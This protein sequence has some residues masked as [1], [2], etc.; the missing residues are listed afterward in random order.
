MEVQF[1]PPDGQLS[2]FWDFQTGATSTLSNPSNIFINPG[3]Y[4]VEYKN[5]QNGPVVGTITINVYP[6]PVLSVETDT[7][8]GCKPLSVV[9]NAV[10]DLAPEI[11]II[12]YEWV[13]G[14]GGVGNSVPEIGHIYN[15]TGVFSPSLGI[16]TNIESCNTTTIFEDLI[17]VS[18]VDNVNFVTSPFPAVSCEPPLEVSFFNFTTG[19]GYIYDWDFG[20]GN[21]F[22]GHMP[23]AEIYTELGNYEVSLTV[24]DTNQ[25]SGMLTRMVNIG[26][27][28]AEFSIPDT[29]CIRDSVVAINLSDPGLYHWESD[30]TVDYFYRT[31]VDQDV[32]IFNAPGFHDVTLTV[33]LPDSSCSSSVTKTVFVD[34]AIGAFSSDP[35]YSCEA[36]MTVDFTPESPDAIAWQ[37]T[38]PDGSISTEEFPS[39]TIEY[40]DEDPFSEYGRK[41][42]LTQLIVTNPSGCRDTITGVDTLYRPD[43]LFMPDVINGCAPL[44]VVFS[45]SSSSQEQ[46]INWHYTFGDGE[47]A[48]LGSVGDVP[49]TYEN[50]G[51]YE[52]QLAIENEAGCLDT[53]YVVTIE[54]GEPIDIDFEPDQAEI[55]P[56]DT[57]QFI[58]LFDSNEIDA[59]HFETDD[60][61]SFHC[62]G[63]SDLNWPFVT[64]TGSYD[65]TLTVEHNG[66]YSTLTKEDVV[67]VK[68]PIAKIDYQINCDDPYVVTFRDSSFDATSVFWEFG[69]DEGSNNSDIDHEYLTTG[70]Y[71]V[72]LTAFN[73]SSG[74]PPDRDT[75]LVCVR[76]LQASFTMNSDKICLGVAVQLDATSSV[77]VDAHCGHGYDWYFDNSSR[78]ITTDTFHLN[79]PTQVTGPENITLVT[80]DVNGCRDT[81]TQTI[82]IYQTVADYSF[83]DLI[84]CAN[85]NNPTSFT[86]L[87]VGDTTLVS[88]Q[89]TFGDGTTSNEQN[90]D[91]IF[92]YPLAPDTSYFVQLLVDDVL[93][94]E[95]VITYEI[96]WYEPTSEISTFPGTP[97]ICIGDEVEFTAADYTAQGSNLIY[98]WD[99]GNGQQSS[100]QT[101][102]VTYG[103]SGIFLVNLNYQEASSGCS[104]T[105]NSLVNVQSYPEA[106]FT[107]SVDGQGVICYP[108]NII[109]FDDSNSEHPLTFLWDFGNGQ[110][111]FGSTPAASFDKGTFSIQMIASTANG[112]SDTTYQQVTLVGPEGD[113]FVDNN[114]IC[115]GESIT[116]QLIDTIDVS[117]YTW[118]FGDGSQE[119]DVNP[120]THDYNVF[121]PG[122]ETVATLV[123]EGQDGACTH[124]VEN[125]IFIRNTQASFLM[126][127]GS[128]TNFCEGQIDFSNTSTG[129]DSFN[130]N[131]GNNQTSTE[132][133][134]TQL[135]AAGEY[136]IILIASDSEFGCSDTTSQHILIGSLSGIE[137]VEDTLCPGGTTI[138]SITNPIE[139]AVY[140]WSPASYFDDPF[141]E[142]QEV[143]L[144]ETTTFNVIVR[145]SMNC[146]GSDMGVISVIQPL[147]WMDIDTSMCPGFSVEAPLP[148]NDG[149]HLFNW[150]PSPPP[151]SPEDDSEFTLTISDILG[152]ESQEYLYNVA[153]L[154]ENEYRIPNV[155]SPNGDDVNDVFR[156]YYNDQF[157][158]QIEIV[159]FWVYNRWGQKVF[160][161]NGPEAIWDGTFKG[162]PAQ[163]D[164]Y[165]FRAEIR[166]TCTEETIIEV[167]EVTLL[168]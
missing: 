87:S 10:T 19:E 83:D 77:D 143:T 17:S 29:V 42:Y 72:I 139:D 67:T 78:P 32:F 28:L 167:G 154:N 65:V 157:S 152:C 104:G 145:D 23:P 158:E 75:A 131:F 22:S 40:P 134:P 1:T 69:D 164:M 8:T 116:F 124:A 55:C 84:V 49:H 118:N 165:I 52:V 140:I 56:G 27:P 38:F 26:G 6:K 107:T 94:C 74:C 4:V 73:E 135:Y 11:E 79:V 43:A 120:V 160:H 15:Q 88:W 129:A 46:I 141:A 96:L 98:D 148:A 37:W 133:N 76:D 121:P 156:V 62:Y 7:T 101:T 153:V 128:A 130:W 54:V 66:C 44:A 138:L 82:R 100:A 159:D 21:T 125:P 161:S 70:D 68:G 137:M 95:G 53:S 106:D 3:T 61:R 155:F 99:F 109:F 60:G 108:E 85:G 64:E 71:N 34:E 18:S 20:N 36:P 33:T 151:F 47:T 51:T 30:Q 48:T 119:S 81:V 110:T 122:G 89:W 146:E 63:D 16:E 163:S 31:W 127:G 112:C 86:D 144:D 24:T 162:K 90:P 58:S 149:F 113:F 142:T 117:S 136:D 35:S 147:P 132:V 80:T 2:H 150:S 114:T 126:N 50:P 103:E 168:R 25:C 93:G 111:A 59:W 92:D 115:L 39:F 12:T 45:D 166:L 123:L 13:F 9:F 97:N 14:D 91:H 57:V 41:L 105:I 102:S 5:D